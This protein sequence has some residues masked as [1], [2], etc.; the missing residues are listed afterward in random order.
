M[1]VS[2]ALTLLVASAPLA[3][4]DPKITS[5]AA[6]ATVAAGTTITVTWADSG[7]PPSV[8]DLTTYTLQLFAGTNAVNAPVKSLPV[9][10]FAAG[11][12]ITLTVEPTIGGSTKNA[13]FIGLLSVAKAG[14]T[15]QS[16]S[17]RFTLSG[18][19]AEFPANIK[20]ALAAGVPSTAGPP[21]I[22]NVV[23]AGANPPGVADAGAWA[24]PYNKQTG[25]TR[26][27]PMQPVPP[28]SIT[29]TNTA[30]LWPTSAVQFA[31]TH[32]PIPTVVTTLTQANTFSVSSHANTAASA[33]APVD[34]MHKF[35]NRWKD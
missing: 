28:T 13:Y 17:D 11:N 22:N 2:K 29:A 23:A 31:A 4:A 21:K 3:L 7:E 27:A 20:A 1:R 14:G 33:S 15:V 6:G 24:I 16:F 19:T 9:A 26:Y 32:M 12:S 5:P 30:P 8:A 18:M 10:Q 35:L 25:L 34:D